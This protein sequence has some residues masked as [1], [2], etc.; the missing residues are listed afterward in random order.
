LR[1]REVRENLLAAP[2]AQAAFEV[3]ARSDVG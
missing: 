3:I 2:D 1:S